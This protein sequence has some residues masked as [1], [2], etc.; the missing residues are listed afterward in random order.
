MPFNRS[1]LD[2]IN[3]RSCS[4]SLVIEYIFRIDSSEHTK[5]QMVKTHDKHRKPK[6]CP[7]HPMRACGFIIRS[8]YTI[9]TAIALAL[10]ML[11]HCFICVCCVFVFTYCICI[12]VFGF[13]FFPKS[14]SSFFSSSLLLFH[15]IRLLYVHIDYTA[16][17]KSEAT[18]TAQTNEQ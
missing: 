11:Y 5:I 2:F 18:T 10:A 13:S 9:S 6:Y 15:L 4:G 14:S 7:N 3:T 8:K 12:R 16:M 1:D 17:H